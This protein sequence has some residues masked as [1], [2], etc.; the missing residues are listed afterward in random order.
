MYVLGSWHVCV[1]CAPYPYVKQSGLRG[2]GWVNCW[3]GTSVAEEDFVMRRQELFVASSTF[4]G[5]LR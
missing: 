1:T 4:F 5:S 2:W 3:W